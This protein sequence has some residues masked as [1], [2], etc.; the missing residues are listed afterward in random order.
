MSTTETR[1]ANAP[2]PSRQQALQRLAKGMQDDV[3]DY[4]RLRE[5]L[6]TQFALALRHDR[7]GLSAI[8]ENISTL[9]TTLDARRAERVELVDVFSSALSDTPRHQVIARLLAQLPGTYRAMAE[10]LWN[11]LQLL[12][13]ECKALNSRN[14]QL[15]MTQ[16]DIMRRVLSNENDI[17]AAD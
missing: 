8:A 10:L 1:A 13:K 16:H 14:G 3:A 17:Y 15:L 2:P 12:V 5:L 9:C 4:G 11:S 7:A 6:E